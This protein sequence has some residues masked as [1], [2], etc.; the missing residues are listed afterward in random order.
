MNDI[1]S[2]D[3]HLYNLYFKHKTVV[4]LSVNISSLKTLTTMQL[5][6]RVKCIAITNNNSHILV[7][8]RD[9]KLIVIGNKKNAEAKQLWKPH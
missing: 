3:F 9:G 5:K 4:N 7:G 1:S 2:D 8:L 6:E